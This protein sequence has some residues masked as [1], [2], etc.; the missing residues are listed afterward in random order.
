MAC[1]P[2]Q[3]FCPDFDSTAAAV[4]A[5]GRSAFRM[6]ILESNF[7]AVGDP[8]IVIDQKL[9]GQLSVSVPNIV[10]AIMVERP[11]S[12]LWIVP[13]EPFVRAVGVTD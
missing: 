11:I 7:L 13:L 10:L 2:S 8:Q 5:L 3:Q 1:K 4:W 12:G 6:V 9:T